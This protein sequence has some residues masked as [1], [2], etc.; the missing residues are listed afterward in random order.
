MN[1]ATLL[2][3]A[4]RTYPDQIAVRCGDR[5]VDYA[6][7]AGRSARLGQALRGFGLHTGDRVGIVQRN[8]VELLETVYGALM[9]G[10]V[11]VPVNMRLHPREIAFIGRDSGWRALVHTAEFNSGLDSVVDEMP[12]LSVRISTGPTHGELDYEQLMK[13]TSPLPAPVDLYPEA[14]AWLFYTSGTTGRPK[15]VIWTHRTVHNLVLSYLADVYSIQSP[16]VV[17]HAA[18]LS[19]GSGTVS[20]A[21]IARGA[22]N[23]ILHTQ[24][25]EPDT[26]FSLIEA[27][28]VTNIAFLAPTQIVKLLDEFTPGRYDLGSLRCVLYGG[29]PMYTDHLRQALEMF[30][31]VFVQIFGQGE[32]PLTISYLSVLEHVRWWQEGHERLSSAGIARTGIEIRIGDADDNP[33]PPGEIGEILC[34]GEIVMPGYWRNPEA[35]AETLRGGWLHTGDVGKIDERGYLYVLDRSKDMVVS[36][37]NNIYPREV[38]EVLLTH[39]AVAECAVIGIPDDYWGEA[40]HAII[41]L[42]D[43]H[44][45]TA[46]GLVAHCLANM[47]SYKKPRSFEFRDALPK[48]AYGKVMKRELREDYWRGHDRRVGGGRPVEV[49]G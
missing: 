43:G 24:S 6:T 31:P 17:L 18:P 5:A 20:L 19:H 44:S 49:T 47:A 25:F 8:G 26:V 39:P 42:E 29:A 3:Q 16:D 35:T 7:F 40:V 33:V 1:T 41:C 38:E 23:V 48:N 27:H 10:L 30:G 14:V 13:E 45:A 37:G 32:S 4:A 12:E 15:G 36:G 34:R 22:Q 2:T 9:A 46:E 11:V 28:G 21:A